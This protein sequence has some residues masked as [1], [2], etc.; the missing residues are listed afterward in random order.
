MS[1]DNNW[2]YFA[3][4][5]NITGSA[6]YIG[7]HNGTSTNVWEK[8]QIDFT[9][10]NGYIQIIWIQ[11]DTK[12]KIYVNGVLA[13]EHEFSNVVWEDKKVDYSYIGTFKSAYDQS[14]GGYFQGTMDEVRIY[15]K[16]LNNTELTAMF[17]LK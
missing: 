4:N 15:D 2:N 8:K 12:S 7:L 10:D 11:D 6:I 16:V 17:A 14:W 3:Y 9:R 1:H 13:G 5:L